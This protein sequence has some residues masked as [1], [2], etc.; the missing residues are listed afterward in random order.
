MKTWSKIEDEKYSWLYKNNY[1][2][3][4]PMKVVKMFN[5]DKNLSCID[6]GCGRASLSTY[7]INYTGVDVS[8]YII[9]VNKSNRKG[10]YIHTSLDSLDFIKT[11]YDIAICSDVMEHIPPNELKNVLK[12]ISCLSVKNYYFVISTR[13]SIILDNENKNL[14]LSVFSSSIWKDMFLEYFKISYEETLQSLYILE[15]QTKL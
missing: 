15:C 9:N 11:S 12:S 8:E 14:H 2:I 6:L 13:K 7:F 3:G 10:N 4:Q 1:P 5:L